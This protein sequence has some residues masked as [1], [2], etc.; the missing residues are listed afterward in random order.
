MAVRKSN[1]YI[2][3][4]KHRKIYS[5]IMD[6]IMGGGLR[7]CRWDEQDKLRVYD[8]DTEPEWNKAVK[9]KKETER[10]QIGGEDE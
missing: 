9:A 4:K 10:D 5:V 1:E 8:L 2:V 7:L 6:A 3:R